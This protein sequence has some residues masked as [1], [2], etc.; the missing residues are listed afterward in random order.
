MVL[1]AKRVNASVAALTS[2]SVSSA[3]LSF[4]IFSAM[5]SSSASDS[6]AFWLAMVI[7]LLREGDAYLDIAEACRGRAVSGAH[8]LLGLSLSTVGR[9]PQCPIIART[10]SV[11]T[12]PEFRGDSTVAGILDHATSLAALDLP[13]YFCRKLEMVTLVVD[14]PGTVGLH[15]D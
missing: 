6:C 2:T 8:H 1:L 4:R 11:A 13:T 5:R 9:A 3:W 14:G 7:R 10:D 12:V 15:Q